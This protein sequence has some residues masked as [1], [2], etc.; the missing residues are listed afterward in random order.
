MTKGFAVQL[1]KRS[2]DLNAAVRFNLAIPHFDTVDGAAV[3]VNGHR[4]F[5][6]FQ[7]LKVAHDITVGRFHAAAQTIAPP[8][9]SLMAC[10]FSGVVAVSL[11]TPCSVTS[12]EEP[13][14][15]HG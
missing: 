15:F 4:D 8:S 10:S 7:R 1:A 12:I 11:P 6:I 5:V 2:A 9:A 13:N 14:Q 3:A